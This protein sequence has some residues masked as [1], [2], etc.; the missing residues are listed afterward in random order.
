[1]YPVKLEHGHARHMT[2]TSA[3][4]HSSLTPRSV[5]SATCPGIRVRCVHN[6]PHVR[7]VHHVRQSA[8][9]DIS[10][11]LAVSGAEMTRPAVPV[12]GE[13]DLARRYRGARCSDTI[14]TGAAEHATTP[15]QWPVRAGW[16]TARSR[17]DRQIGRQKWVQV[18][19]RKVCRGCHFEDVDSYKEVVVLNVS[20]VFQCSSSNRHTC[21]N[22]NEH[23]FKGQDSQQFNE[24]SMKTFDT[25]LPS[26]Y[27][28]G[29]ALGKE[30]EFC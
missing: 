1:M 22:K 19:Y 15:M 9:S 2:D 23:E 30:T 17:P 12:R 20:R 28:K 27:D 3:E 24:R 8:A 5:V 4:R 26:C 10:A 18:R 16:C 11:V 6:V 13:A 25:V 7:N 29:C 14:W 21:T